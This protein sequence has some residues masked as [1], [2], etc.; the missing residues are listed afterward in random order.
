MKKSFFISSL[1]L[2][3][4]HFSIAQQKEF[5]WLVG[6]WKLKDKN[7]F[8]VWK[9]A[10]DGKELSG[11][12]FRTKTSDTTAMESIRLVYADDSFHYIPDV[13]GDQPPVDFRITKYDKQSF[14]AENPLHDF[15]K[16]IRYRFTEKEN[17]K[18]IEA[19][20]EGNGKVIPY[21]FEKVK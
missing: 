17:K 20:I 18:F 19:T 8:E 7:V 6:T 13:P 15:P 11:F 3:L 1:C 21:D 5:G 2:L 16:I 10:A 4:T 14:V 9:V 12:S